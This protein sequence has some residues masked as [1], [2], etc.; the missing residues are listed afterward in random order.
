MH[1]SPS[2]SVDDLIALAEE[3]VG[4]SLV[5][6]HNLSVEESQTS[7]AYSLLAIAKMMRR[8]ESLEGDGNLERAT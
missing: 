5:S 3:H 8:N 4:G 6:D 7:I 1:D 2:V